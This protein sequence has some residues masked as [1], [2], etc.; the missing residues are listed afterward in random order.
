M[1]SIIFDSSD[2]LPLM[3][4]LPKLKGQFRGKEEGRTIKI[5][6]RKSLSRSGINSLSVVNK[7]GN[8]EI[9]IPGK[10]DTV[11]VP[12]MGRIV[13]SKN[14]ADIGYEGYL[15]NLRVTAF[16]IRYEIKDQ[17]VFVTL[18][19]VIEQNGYELVEILTSSLVS[20]TETDGAAWLAHGDGGGYYTDMA[21]ARICI[22]K[23]GWS[24]D[25]PYFPNFTYLPLVLMGNG[26]V[27]TS[28]EVQGYLSNTQLEVFMINRKKGAPWVLKASTG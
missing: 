1:V 11:I 18:E 10:T 16:T 5:V 22:L 27:N 4:D 13:L 23:D 9:Y 24:K 19:D 20:V 28:L 2:G 17:S 14:I 3:Y 6:V 8:G 7:T 15:D 12:I 26:K 21:A 25:F